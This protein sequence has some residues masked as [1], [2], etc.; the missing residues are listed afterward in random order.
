MP[1]SFA[2]SVESPVGV[3]QILAAF[4]DNNYWQ[5]RLAVGGNDSARVDSLVVDAVGAVTVVLKASV[6]RERLPKVAAKVGRGDLETIHSEQWIPVDGGRVR[7]EV[8]VT[9]RGAPVSGLCEA[10]LTPVSHGSRW[11]VNGTV[12]VKVP[13]VGG[14][15]ESMIGSQVAT[16]VTE[17]QRFTAEW[18]AENR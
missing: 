1:R 15:I 6:L 11:E 9:M 13:L 17:L 7:G 16:G 14:P 3:D 8:R 2:Y 18:I 10:L 4:G 12:A 5:A